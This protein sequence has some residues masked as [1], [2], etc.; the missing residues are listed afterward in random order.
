MNKDN[1]NNFREKK[2]QPSKTGPSYYL[3]RV[4]AS[5]KCWINTQVVI[6]MP[7]HYANLPKKENKWGISQMISLRKWK[8]PLRSNEIPLLLELDPQRASSRFSIC[9]VRS[10]GNAYLPEP[11]SAF[12]KKK[13]N[14][15]PGGDG[16]RVKWR[17]WPRSGTVIKA[18]ADS[19]DALQ[20][21]TDLRLCCTVKFVLQ[22]SSE[23]QW[24]L[25][26][27]CNLFH[28]QQIPLFFFVS[29]PLLWLEG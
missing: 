9:L 11:S 26:E 24:A 29:C 10:H 25:K 3:L 21:H 28:H 4:C 13:K 14:H 17:S 16:V 20:F 7:L 12:S 15:K 6:F 2:T 19:R 23:E 18:F 22:H 27:H 8:A 1:N 5:A